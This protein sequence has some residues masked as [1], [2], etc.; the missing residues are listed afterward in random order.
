ML[1]GLIS[2]SSDPTVVAVA[3]LTNSQVETGWMY[4]EV[5]TDEAKADEMQ[6]FAAGIAEGYLTRWGRVATP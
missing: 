3:N 4:L 1:P 6:A 2:F 5:Q